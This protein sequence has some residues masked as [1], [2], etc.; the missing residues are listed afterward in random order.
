MSFVTRLLPIL[1]L[2]VVAAAAPAADA[3]ATPAPAAG[4]AEDAPRIILD[5]VGIEQVAFLGQPHA[6]LLARFP[7]AQ[8][9]P[10]AGQ[11][12]AYTVKIPAA[13][14]SC[15]V[16]G[17]TPEALKVASA[18]F[19][20]EGPYE[21]IAPGRFRTAR[22]IG[23][24]S[25]VN[26]LIE[27]YGPPQEIVK[28]RAHR[29]AEADDPAVPALYQYPNADGSV[30][31]SFVVQQYRVVRIALHQIEPINRHILKKRPPVSS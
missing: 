10:F 21:G 15:M 31:M 24:G 25:T 17:D 23:N 6:D 28:D 13:G 18:G 30:T 8:V 11:K 1:A 20:I 19:L 26:D 12:D 22:G 14:I 2:S 3:G 27:A 29:T 16:V 4:A 7:D 9:M 5:H